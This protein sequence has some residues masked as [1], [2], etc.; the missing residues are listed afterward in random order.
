MKPATAAERQAKRRARMRERGY[1]EVT[2][3]IPDRDHDKNRLRQFAAM[4]RSEYEQ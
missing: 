3:K 2:I 1:T 4:L